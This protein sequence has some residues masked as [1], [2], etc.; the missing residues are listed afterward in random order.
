MNLP[1]NMTYK[2]EIALFIHNSSGQYMHVEAKKKKQPRIFL[3]ITLI[4]TLSREISFYHS[5]IHVLF[6]KSTLIDKIRT[7]FCISFLCDNKV[8]LW[9]VRDVMSRWWCDGPDMTVSILIHCGNFAISCRLV[10]WLLFPVKVA[11][12]IT[13]SSH[14]SNVLFFS[15][16]VKSIIYGPSHYGALWW[17]K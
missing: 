13:Y 3:S 11:Q 15:I 5:N 8:T 12:P 17:C 7:G 9:F 14:R 4:L 6:C 10:M 2:P 16:C 1:F